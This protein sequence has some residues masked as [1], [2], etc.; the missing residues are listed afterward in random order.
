MFHSTG[1]KSKEHIN[2]ISQWHNQWRTVKRHRIPR[3]H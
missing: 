1:T 2:L 3:K